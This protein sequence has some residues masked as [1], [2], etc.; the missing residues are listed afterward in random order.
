MSPFVTKINVKRRVDELGQGQGAITGWGVSQTCAEKAGLFV[1]LLFF[2]LIINV[3]TISIIIREHFSHVHH[4]S[5]KQSDS[6]DISTTSPVQ[7]RPR[8]GYQFS[9][10]GLPGSDLQALEQPRP[11]SP[12][13]R[14]R[15]SAPCPGRSRK[16][17]PPVSQRQRME[18]AASLLGPGGSPRPFPRG[19]L[20]GRPGVSELR[21]WKAPRP[22]RPVG[23]CP[24][25][26]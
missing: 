25:Q 18:L 10:S 21:P 13:S 11:T 17:K 2:F 24:A 6:R 15:T 3:C 5:L 19:Q 1:G 26:Q 22:S 16:Q 14:R 20:P 12:E 7:L 9:S 4:I 23:P 8:A